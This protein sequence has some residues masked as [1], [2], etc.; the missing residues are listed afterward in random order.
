MIKMEPLSDYEI[1]RFINDQIGCCH[2][3]P[4]DIK[5]ILYNTLVMHYTKRQVDKDIFNDVF[6]KISRALFDKE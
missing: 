6:N 1:A 3:L 4:P 2:H 5:N